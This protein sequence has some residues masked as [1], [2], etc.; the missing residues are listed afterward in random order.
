ML[1]PAVSNCPVAEGDTGAPVGLPEAVE[2]VV[3]AATGWV[4]GDAEAS[5]RDTA[6]KPR[7]TAAA[8]DAV[9]AAPSA[10]VRFMT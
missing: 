8:A 9:H 2:D 10:T 4:P 5:T 3:V 6:R 7:P 1:P